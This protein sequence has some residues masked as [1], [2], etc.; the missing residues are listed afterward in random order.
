MMP[1]VSKF[2]IEFNGI[3]GDPNMGAHVA[4]YGDERAKI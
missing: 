4:M 3:S 1:S 2:I